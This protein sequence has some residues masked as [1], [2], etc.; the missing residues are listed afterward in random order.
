MFIPSYFNSGKQVTKTS[1]Y[2]L[3]QRFIQ[4]HEEGSDDFRVL[5]GSLIICPHL[6]RILGA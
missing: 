1:T 6:A 3:I 5:V 4:Y 2:A